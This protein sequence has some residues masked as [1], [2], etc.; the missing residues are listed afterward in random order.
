MLR[1]THVTT[2][3]VSTTLR[4]EGRIEGDGVAV[5]AKEIEFLHREGKR[6]VLDFEAVEFVD[7]DG[8]RMLQETA[9]AKTRIV[10]CSA[11][12]QALLK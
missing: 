8:V 5:L 9:D 7:R 3:K 2:N 6:V 10:H 4:V 1:I 11:F 12:I